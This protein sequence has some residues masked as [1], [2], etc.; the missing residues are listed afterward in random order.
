MRRQVVFVPN[1]KYLPHVEVLEDRTLLSVVLPGT[2][3]LHVP[4]TNLLGD[5]ALLGSFVQTSSIA[6]PS[7]AAPAE[8][9]PSLRVLESVTIAPHLL[10]EISSSTVAGTPLDAT[11]AAVAGFGELD[12]GYRGTIHFASTDGQ[13]VLPAD[14]TFTSSD[15]GIHTFALGVTLKTAGSQTVSVDDTVGGAV[16]ATAKVQVSPANVDHLSL[17]AQ[18][19]SVAGTAF[20]MTVSAR[21]AY[22]N[23][24]SD[25]S[26]T[27]HF[28]SSDTQATLPA[29]YSFTTG[30]HGTH[31]FARALT[32]RT[33]GDQTI[34]A[35]D[36]K[37]ITGT[38]DVQVSAASAAR[39]LVVPASDTGT[40]GGPLDVTVTAKD[41]FGN[42][43]TAYTGTV[44]FG[45][46]DP[47]AG[48]P[49]NY[50][51]SA[52]DAGIHTFPVT[53][54]TAG[55]QTFTV[56][57]PVNLIS[58][59]TKVSVAEAGT[60]LGLTSSLQSSVYGQSVSFTATVEASGAVTPTGTV[61]FVDETIGTDLGTFGLTAG[62]AT[63]SIATLGA[64]GHTIEAIYSGDSNYVGSTGSTNFEV[65]PAALTVTVDNST[66]RY[67]DPLPDF[68]VS[69]SDF[70]LG[71]G[72]ND[73]TGTLSFATAATGSSHVGN[74]PVSVSGV[75]DPN[76]AISFANGALSV[77]PVALTITANNQLKPYGAALPTLTA[78]YAGF[79]NGD[80]P[81]SLA[82]QPTLSTNA[83]AASHVAGNPCTITADGAVDPDYTINY[84][85]GSLDVTPATLTITADNQTKQYGS[86]LPLFTASYNGFVNGDTPA[87][88]TSPLVLG[89]QANIGSHVGAYDIAASGAADPD[90]AITFVDGTLEVTP[91]PLTV[92]ADNQSR[93]FGAA[94]PTFAVAYS[95]F[96]LGQDPGALQ[97]TLNVTTS[98]TTTS[99]VGDYAITP[100]G[101]SSTDYAL[102]YVDG[103]LSVLQDGTSTQVQSAANPTVVGHG[104]LV[105]ALVSPDPPGSGIPTGTI[106]F[107][108]GTTVLGTAPL[109]G[110]TASLTLTGLAVGFHDITASYAGDTNF[111]GNLGTSLS[112]EIDVLTPTLQSLA[113]NSVTEGSQAVTLTLTGSGFETDASAY[114]NGKALATTFVSSTQLQAV[115]PA[116]AVTE[117]GSLQITVLNPGTGNGLS[118]PK[119]L[120]ITDAPLTE[121]DHAFVAGSGMAFT[122]TVASFT[123][124][125][126]LAQPGDF[127][128]SIDWGDGVISAGVVEANASGG[129]NVVGMHTFA[130]EDTFP[131]TVTI[132]DKGGSTTTAHSMAV[133]LSASELS[134]LVAWDF[135]QATPGESVLTAHVPGVAGTLTHE[136]GTLLHEYLFVGI[137]RSDPTG[138]PSDG[139]V[140][141]ETRTGNLQ[142]GDVLTDTCGYPSKDNG[143]PS[144]EYFKVQSQGFLDY[145]VGTQP[146][147]KEIIDTQN[148]DIV[149]TFDATSTPSIS[150]LHGTVFTIAVSNTGGE[151]NGPGTQPTPA[152]I[153]PA[154]A[155]AGANAAGTNDFSR[156][157]TFLSSNQLSLALT[158]S[159]DSQLT[160]SR[161]SASSGVTSGGGD[162]EDLEDYFSFLMRVL[163]KDLFWE[164]LKTA[165]V[166]TVSDT[167][168]AERAAVPDPA[169]PQSAVLPPMDG[170][171]INDFQIVP[172]EG[173]NQPEQPEMEHPPMKEGEDL[174]T[175]EVL[176]V[177]LAGWTLWKRPEGK[178]DELSTRRGVNNRRERQ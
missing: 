140:F 65:A 2:D 95:G 73:L 24:V 74:Y 135:E 48:L 167:F 87:S 70:V 16:T 88:L 96:V 156:Q 142:N 80:T 39:L 124:A 42:V 20:G 115:L 151:G 158:P 112:Q 67:G 46:S 82:V 174:D 106:T 134:L 17:N 6:M 3:L 64:A 150:N 22:G 131:V 137:Y 59:S 68:T 78:S 117:A 37:G 50:S 29:N 103:H 121:T 155:L 93:V 79:V 177:A 31:T 62:S 102:A 97:G 43:A 8:S 33:A 9:A 154:L 133:V 1:A 119:M 127:T 132:Q 10:L 138:V 110:G 148:H 32:L 109:I 136:G 108:E 149:C 15:G 171:P 12:S 165:Q 164:V 89:S 21:D 40:V 178:R 84:V 129:F 71:Q 141:C 28:I 107:L 36:A 145:H 173:F 90:Y 5:A 123:D 81:A 99:V 125:N 13:G 157:T 122:G 176:S 128:A 152:T 76:Y 44:S 63:L 114:A 161:T 49:G 26:G 168:V 126:S 153:T 105:T 23:L 166:P 175:I 104:V 86:A 159:S 66:K 77:T 172:Q 45:S 130:S 55:L 147:D 116:S 162:E 120:T 98:A 27:V 139:V 75:S 11:V 144:F 111:V 146:T 30:D 53:F 25:Y 118:A 85:P 143:T 56:N 54:N 14:Y 169:A 92:T 113:P 72:P 101:L 160:V 35:T 91:A 61:E 51:F 34:S 19:A 94:N 4:V 60:A 57:D 83:A 100:A 7:S 18:G 163:G 41:D 52:N 47:A 170:A 58:G 69:Y 38:T